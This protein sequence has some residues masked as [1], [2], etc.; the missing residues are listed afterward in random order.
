MK[1]RNA[2]IAYDISSNQRRRKVYRCLQA[3]RL[4]SQYSVFE[5]SLSAPEARE[6]FTQLTEFINP[7]TDKL[8]LVWLDANRQAE[9]ITKAASI[10]FYQPVWYIAA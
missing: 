2:L 6:L 8:C 3:W 7:D 1:R 9:A 4:S 10:G 5:C